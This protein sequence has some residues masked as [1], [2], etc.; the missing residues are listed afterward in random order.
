MAKHLSTIAFSTALTLGLIV[1]MQTPPARVQAAALPSAISA[2]QPL[3]SSL[4]GNE[5]RS[6]R[7]STSAEKATR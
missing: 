7:A 6:L 2:S 1:G 5:I 4:E 3:Y